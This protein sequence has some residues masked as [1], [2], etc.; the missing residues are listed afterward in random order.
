VRRYSGCPTCAPGGFDSGSPGTVYF[1]EHYE[2][3][4]Q[5]VGITS[6]K[7]NRIE[8]F[9]KEGWK[10]VKKWEFE[11]GSIALETETL[12]FHWLRKEEK[13]PRYLGVE[14]MPRTGGS[15]ETFE[16][17]VMPSQKVVEKIEEL[18]KFLGHQTTH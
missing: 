4:A 16:M 14:E 3:M 7:S 17:N 10:L 15:S 11:Y 5:K 13:L 2:L 9:R 8:K 6:A 18:A 12:F 1:I